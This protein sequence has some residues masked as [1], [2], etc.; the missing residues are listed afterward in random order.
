MFGL[1]N[2]QGELV[3]ANVPPAAYLKWSG[4]WGLLAATVTLAFLIF[5]GPGLR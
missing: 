1:P 5:I 3:S 4:T 2:L